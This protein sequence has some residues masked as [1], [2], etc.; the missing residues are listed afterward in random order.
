MDGVGLPGKIRSPGI[1][2]LLYVLT[3]G[4]YGLVWHWKIGNEIDQFNPESK[5]GGKL[6]A[7][8]ILNIIAYAVIM[9]GAVLLLVAYLPIFTADEGESITVQDEEE[10]MMDAIPAF[11]VMGFGALLSL[12]AA[13]FH[14]MGMHRVWTTTAMAQG[15]R[16][17]QQI[18]IGM[19]MTFLIIYYA[20]NFVS[21]I[22]ILGSLVSLA[23]IVLIIVLYVMTQ[24]AL[25]EVWRDY[26][27]SG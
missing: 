24:N 17:R 10:A 16:G 23:A 7:F 3:F 14:I 9:I 12:T 27:A 25:N 15:A 4:I 22:P 5:A 11:I 13:V 21:W 20:N 18:S 26:G 1:N 19:M 2:F 8:V 6:H